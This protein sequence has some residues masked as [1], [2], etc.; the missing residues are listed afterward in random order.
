MS[1]K[2]MKGNLF[3]YDDSL[4]CVLVSDDVEY[5]VSPN[6]TVLHLSI[7]ADVGIVRLNTTNG[8]TDLCGLCSS[9]SKGIC[10]WR[11]MKEFITNLFVFA[12][13]PQR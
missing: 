8:A 6:N 3:D 7:T 13:I 11:W 9:H 10:T 4:L 1:I 2:D 12:C 5:V